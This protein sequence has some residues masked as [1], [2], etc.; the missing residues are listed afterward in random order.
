MTKV[1]ID[2]VYGPGS[3][4]GG[5]IQEHVDMPRAPVVG[6]AIEMIRTGEHTAL[7]VKGVT[8]LEGD[9]GFVAV[10]RVAREAPSEDL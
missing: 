2:E 9:D 5:R 10:V 6:E 4:R 3:P 1:F 8:W 7:E